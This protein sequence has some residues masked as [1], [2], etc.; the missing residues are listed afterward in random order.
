MDIVQKEPWACDA[1]GYMGLTGEK[2]HEL[3]YSNVGRVFCDEE[4]ANA[5][6][7]KVIVA[8]GRPPKGQVTSD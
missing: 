1:C 5:W 2:A 3:T 8:L 7:D 6:L 4:C